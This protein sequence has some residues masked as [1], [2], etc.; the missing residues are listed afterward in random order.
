[1]SLS[2]DKSAAIDTLIPHAGA[3]VLLDQV[4][5]CDNEQVHCRANL[6]QIADHPL[7][8]RG[9][10]PTTALPEYAAQAMAV[11]SALTGPCRTVPREGR[12]VAL[13]EFDLTTDHIEA[14]VLIDVH[15]TCVGGDDSG[16]LYTFR[17]VDGERSLASGR[18]TV[19]FVEPGKAE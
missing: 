13:P 16:A 9:Q 19:M 6:S 5:A 14:P 2:P 7:A 17:I 15:A 18:A 4:V 10:L 3:M 11:H 8:H 12:L 1:M